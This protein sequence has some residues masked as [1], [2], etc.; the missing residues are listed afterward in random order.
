MDHYLVTITGTQP[1][2]MH[3]DDI[4]WA[5]QMTAWKDDKDNKKGSK[6]GD[7]RSPSWR[8]LG[9]LYHD[10]EQ[11]VFPMENIMRSLMEGGAMVPVPGGRAGK[12]FKAQTQSGIQPLAPS[13]PLL[14]NGKTIKVGK[15]LKLVGNANFE[16]HKEAALEHGFQLFIKRA[17]I[18]ASKH[19]RVRPEFMTWEITG[20]LAISDEQITQAILEDIL[21]MSGRYK[22]LGDW[23][24]SSKTPGFRGMFVSTVKLIKSR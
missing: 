14:V 12:T 18:G 10:G 5:D 9:N 21:E 13:W 20:E 17:K 19:V 4:E 22:G 16:K 11:I 1:L 23:R 6:A 2:L 7:D 3:A 24:P 15:L 8:W